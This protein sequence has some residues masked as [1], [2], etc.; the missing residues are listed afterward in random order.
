MNHNLRNQISKHYLLSL[1]LA[2]LSMLNSEA[3]TTH[4]VSNDPSHSEIADFSNLQTAI[5]AADEYDTILIYPTGIDYSNITL[6]KP[7]TLQSIGYNYKPSQQASLGIETFGPNPIVNSLNIQNTNNCFISGLNIIFLTL[8]NSY[9]CTIYRNSVSGIHILNS[10]TSAFLQNYIG[11]LYV[12]QYYNAYLDNSNDIILSNNIFWHNN[13]SPPHHNLT[14]LSNCGNFACY[15]NI[16]SDDVII[17]N[18]VVNNSIFILGLNTFYNTVIENNAFASTITGNPPNNQYN[19]DMATVFVGY[20]AQGAYSF[21]SRYQLL[22]NSPARDYGVNGVDC[23]VFDGDFPYRLS[24]ITNRP[25][26]SELVVPTSTYND[27]MEI[28][29]RVKIID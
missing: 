20:P 27:Q 6:S 28:T 22:P 2:L 17:H 4:W 21:D 14:V 5:N 25:I 10:S 3:Q 18:G 11:G 16:F 12:N 19:V 23:G 13:P 15:N 26:V 9:N 8:Q 29:V 24:G 7:L 1:S